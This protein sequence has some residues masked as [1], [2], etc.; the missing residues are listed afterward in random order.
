MDRPHAP[1]YAKCQ[2][3]KTEVDGTENLINCV[4]ILICWNGL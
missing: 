3:L 2:T 1:S 4:H